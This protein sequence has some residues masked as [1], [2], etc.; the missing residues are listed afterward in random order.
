M[1]SGVVLALAF[2][3]MQQFK[4]EHN[5]SRRVVEQRSLESIYKVE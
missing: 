4:G 2:L 5:S 3:P 1:S